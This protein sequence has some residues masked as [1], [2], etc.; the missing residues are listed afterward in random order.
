M[1]FAQIISPI[2]FSITPFLVKNVFKTL[3]SST[4]TPTSMT[5]LKDFLKKYVDIKTC[6]NKIITNIVNLLS[7]KPTLPSNSKFKTI[8]NKHLNLIDGFESVKFTNRVKI[9]GIIYTDKTNKSKFNDGCI[10]T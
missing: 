1:I 3:L 4:I 10:Q 8:I 7:I 2:V 9:N 6:N 5:A